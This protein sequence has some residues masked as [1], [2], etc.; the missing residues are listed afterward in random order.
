MRG[1]FKT[2]IHWHAFLLEPNAVVL[3]TSRL[4][5]I[6][7][8]TRMESPSLGHHTLIGSIDMVQSTLRILDAALVAA[9]SSLD[10]CFARR[11][12]RAVRYSQ[13]ST[14]AVKVCGLR[15]RKIRSLDGFINRFGTGSVLLRTSSTRSISLSSRD[16]KRM[17]WLKQFGVVAY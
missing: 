13:G 2:Q 5:T 1:W 11:W 17:R 6:Q 7:V 16:P 10:T 3:L 9:K 4:I 14:V 8:P 15:S 12:G